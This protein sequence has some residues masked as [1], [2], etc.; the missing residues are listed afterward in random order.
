MRFK[1]P[2]MG[3]DSSFTLSSLTF[4]N[5]NIINRSKFLRITGGIALID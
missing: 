3:F 1:C 2:K 4:A 5:L